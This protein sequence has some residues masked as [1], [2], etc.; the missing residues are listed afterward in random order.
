MQ[1]RAGSVFVAA[2]AN[3]VSALPPELL[4]KGRFDEVWWVDLP[5]A[6]EREAIVTAAMR[7]YGRT[8]TVDAE[9]VARRTAGFSGAEI[10]ALIPDALFRAFADNGRP[11]VTGDLIQAAGTVVPLSKTASERIE[12]LR[13]WAAGRAR[14]ASEMPSAGGEARRIDL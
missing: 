5:N 9:A 4:R 10:A 12:A 3:D 2:T 11:L 6:T 1:D 8:E 14:A 13:R 7:Q